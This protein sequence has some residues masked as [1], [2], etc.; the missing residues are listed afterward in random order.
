VPFYASLS[1][2][3]GDL[4]DRVAALGIPVYRLPA[5]RF[6]NVLQTA[7]KIRGL[8]RV[9]R[10]TQPHVVMSNSGHPLLFAR[11]AALA[12]GRPCVW[13]VHGYFPWDALRGHFIHVAQQ[14]IAADAIL[15]VSE[16]TARVMRLDYGNYPPIRVARCGTRLDRFYPDSEAGQRVRHALGIRREETVVG[17]F[18][19]LQPWKGQH[20]F[21]AAVERLECRGVKCKYLVVGGSLFGLDLEYAEHLKGFVREHGLSHCLHFL[22]HRSDANELMNACDVVV[23]SSVE[24]EPGSLVVM[25]VMA[26]GRPLIATHAGGTPERVRHSETGLLFPLGDADRLAE[27]IAELAQDPAK[28]QRLGEAARRYAVEHCDPR[29]AAAHL[30]AELE[31]VREEYR[32]KHR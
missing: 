29:R 5:G 27:L 4:P 9:I 25:E 8:Y 28:R 24:P 3:W 1:F 30:C 16:D 31:R 21:L 10:E 19:R 17:I 22:G 18:G 23:Q 26:A 6:R 13:W 14:Q 32:A 7:K 15:T 11:P 20:V 12:A 2:G